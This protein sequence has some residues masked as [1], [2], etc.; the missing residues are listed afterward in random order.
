[1]ETAM[2][3]RRRILVEK[4]SIRAVA[5]ATGLSRNTIRKYCRDEEPPKYKRKTSAT[6]RVLKDY[7]DQLTQWYEQDLDRPKRERRTAKKLFEQL[8][9]EGYQGSYSPVGRWIKQLKESQPSPI[10][11]FIPLYVSEHAYLTRVRQS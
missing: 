9:L 1:M 2:K 5:K 8:I 3:V 4:Q 6:L 11:A 10:D 7:E